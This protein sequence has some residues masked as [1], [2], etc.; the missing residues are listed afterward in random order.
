MSYKCGISSMSLGR[1]WV[2]QLPQKLDQAAN[3]AYDGVEIFYEDL[4]YLA[5]SYPG[6]LTNE[7]ILQASREIRK[8]CD[9]R[10][11]DIIC[12]QPF[13]CCEGLADA[14]ERAAM[15]EKLKLWFQIAKILGTGI[16]QI[17]SNIRA[18]G[19][20]GDREVII[21]D[22]QEIADLGLQQ[23]PVIRFAYESLCF[24]R[25]VDTWEEAWKIIVAVDR[26]NFGTCLDTF[27][28]AGREWA[29]PSAPDGKN[30][31]ADEVLKQSMAKLRHTIDVNKVFFIQVVDAEKM[32]NPLTKDHIFHVEGQLP[33]MSWSRNARLFPFE[34]SGYLPIIDVLKA[35]TDEDGLNY[36]GW[37]SLELFSRTMADPDPACPRKHAARGMESW[38]KLVKVMGWEKQVK[39]TRAFLGGE[40][41]TEI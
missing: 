34:K 8:M 21:R 24:G 2:H 16:I 31:N 10:N 18:E 28:I 23:E 6:G 36:K 1:A 41:K 37:V 3:Y 30:P 4:E 17:P 20:T 32:R 26:P 22:F 7:N 13:M 14:A 19:T 40:N 38:K 11:L 27:N 9:E 12:L 35:I 29:D 39:G 33:R 15:I 25:Y 5:K